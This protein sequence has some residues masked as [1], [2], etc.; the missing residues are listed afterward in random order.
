M[1]KDAIIKGVA[2]WIDKNVVPNLAP[3]GALR[4]SVKGA[5]A[6][7]GQSPDMALSLFSLKFPNIVAIVNQ[8]VNASA[9]PATMDSMVEAFKS[10]IKEEGG[11]V[12]QFFEVGLW[13]NIPHSLV[14]TPELIDELYADIKS[15]SVAEKT[16]T[17]PKAV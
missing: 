8:F 12:I 7:A 16:K 13:N 3:R 5:I 9:T 2:M 6:L 14:V 17:A 11:M 10:A 15:A 1:T 4:V